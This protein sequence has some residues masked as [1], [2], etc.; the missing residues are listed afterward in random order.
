M[1]VA[2]IA[3]NEISSGPLSLVADVEQIVDFSEDVPSARVVVLYAAA[4]VY[5]SVDRSAATV[6]GKNCRPMPPVPGTMQFE[7]PGAGNTQIRLISP[8]AVTVVVTKV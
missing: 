6:G 7:V 5:F 4:P 2:T 1:P 8:G 3:T